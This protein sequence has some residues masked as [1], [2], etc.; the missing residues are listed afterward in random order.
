M[1]AIFP[2]HISFWHKATKRPK[3]NPIN[4]KSVAGKRRSFLFYETPIWEISLPIGH[5]YP[6]DMEIM[7][8]FINRLS[9]THETFYFFDPMNV[10]E[11]V[12]IGIGDGAE[13][14]FQLFRAWGDEDLFKE[15]PA[16]PATYL[17]NYF[18]YGVDGYLTP[19]IYGFGVQVPPMPTVYCDN[20]V[21]TD[22]YSITT[23]GIIS[24]DDAPAIGVPVTASFYFCYL[25]ALADDCELSIDFFNGWS[26]NLKLETVKS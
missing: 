14:D 10:Q 20:V 7:T 2:C 22:G 4:R 19:E 6:A 9:G 18:G 1:D 24:F 21:Q 25:A 15:Y 11:N 13:T 23:A 16:Y 8:G 3:F 26:T 12:E 5:L 17:S